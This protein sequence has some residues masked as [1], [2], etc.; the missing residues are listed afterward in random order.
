MI[1]HMSRSYLIIDIETIVDA[2]L[3]LPA[4]ADGTLLPPAPYH[5]IVTIGALWMDESYRPLKLG[6]V[7]SSK[8][9]SEV[10]EAFVRFVQERRPDLVTYNGR[11]FDLP[12]IVARCLRHGIPFAHYFQSSGVRYRYSSEGHLDLMD[13]MTDYG[14]SRAVPLDTLTKLIGLPGKVGVDGKDVGPMVHAG[15]IDEV[16]AYC[17]CDVVQTAGLFLR[18][19]LLRG[20]LD[21]D[22]YRKAMELLL[23]MCEEDARVHP[24]FNAISKDALLLNARPNQPSKPGP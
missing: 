20:I 19:Q 23:R 15:R 10:L 18:I 13:F 8:S 2:A 14:A 1:D 16:Y 3:P 9:E 21:K 11:G 5:Q 6:V 22:A 17:L 12:V 4:K 24:V 7:G